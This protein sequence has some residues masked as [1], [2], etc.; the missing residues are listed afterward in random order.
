MLGSKCFCNWEPNISV[1]C[2]GKVFL[3]SEISHFMIQFV[4]GDFCEIKYFDRAV[5]KRSTEVSSCK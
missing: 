1:Y 5:V 3:K 4:T 2:I